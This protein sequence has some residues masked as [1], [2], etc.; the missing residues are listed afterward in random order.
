VINLTDKTYYDAIYASG[1]PFSYIA[2]GRTILG[3]IAVMF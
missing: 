2:P 3:S 1:A